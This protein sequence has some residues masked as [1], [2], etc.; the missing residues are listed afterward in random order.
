MSLNPGKCHFG[1]TKLRILGF[2]VLEGRMS[3]DPNKLKVVKD[4]KEPGNL[5]EARKLLGFFAFLRR[6]VKNFS[7]IIAPIANS[8]KTTTTFKWAREQSVA[9][10]ALKHAL[11]NVGALAIFDASAK[12]VVKSDAF[13]IGLGCGL[14]QFNQCRKRY[15]PVAYASRLMTP[16]ERRFASSSVMSETLGAVYATVVFRHYLAG[17]RWTLQCDS[18][19]V[20]QILNNKAHTLSPDMPDKMGIYLLH[21]QAFDFVAVWKPNA[22]MVDVDYISRH[23]DNSDIS[24]LKLT[25]ED[26]VAQVSRNLTKGRMSILSN[27]TERVFFTF[28]NPSKSFIF[29]RGVRL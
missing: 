3:I 13:G 21:L 19:A 15:L 5:R 27:I 26:W 22:Q 20:V 11:L 18:E 23:F 29:P 10:Q 12:T 28:Q 2:E 4:F 7:T 24:Y 8:L 17:I 25:I 6:Y 9:L 14:F 16:T 1:Y